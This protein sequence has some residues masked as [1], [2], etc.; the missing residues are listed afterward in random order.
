MDGRWTTP[1]RLELFR[2]AGFARERLLVVNTDVSGAQDASGFAALAPNVPPLNVDAEGG[3]HFVLS[4]ETPDGFRIEGVEFA[5]LAGLPGS[6]VAAAGGFTVTVWR[7][8]SVSEQ[9]NFGKQWAAYN[10][11]VGVGYDQLYHSFDSN[12]V[13]IRFQIGNVQ[14]HGSV[15]IVICEI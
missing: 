5:F 9:I 12:A 4:P 3:P 15:P 10:P 2:Q 1:D 13:A 8:I 6:A 7:F 11:I 14:T